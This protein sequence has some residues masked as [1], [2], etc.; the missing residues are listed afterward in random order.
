MRRGSGTGWVLPCLGFLVPSCALYDAIWGNEANQKRVAEQRAPA[1]L[2]RDSEVPPDASVARKL[3]VRV[4]ATPRYAAATVN[5]Q[6]QFDQVVDDANP[7]LRA[8]LGVELEVVEYLVW[9]DAG[10]ED[11]LPDLLQRLGVR[12]P[13]RDVD[14]VVA[15]ATAVPEL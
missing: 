13:G 11:S 9:N 3:G 2:R 1:A 14:W 5:W 6:H 4:Y 8:D 12:D 10:S 15:L 7:T